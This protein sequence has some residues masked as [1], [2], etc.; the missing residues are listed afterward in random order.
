MP[1]LDADHAPLTHYSSLLAQ[2]QVVPFI[3]SDLQ[4]WQ[5]WSSGNQIKLKGSAGLCLSIGVPG[6]AGGISNPGSDKVA[7]GAQLQLQSCTCER[8]HVNDV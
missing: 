6:I 1:A 3:G 4:L 5:P 7:P 8:V 2:V